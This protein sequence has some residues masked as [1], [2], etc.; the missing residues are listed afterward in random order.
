MK[1]VSKNIFSLLLQRVSFDLFINSLKI[2][3]VII[4]IIVNLI[5]LAGLIFLKW[6]PVDILV[7][8]WI[9]SVVV[10]MVNVPKI[11]FAKDLSRSPFKSTIPGQNYDSQGRP[12]SL[13]GF[14]PVFGLFGKLLNIFTAFFFLFHYGFFNFG[15]WIFINF[16][17]RTQVPDSSWI[18]L[19]DRI[20]VFFIAT[21]ISHSFSFLYN[22]IGKGE[23][24][25]TSVNEQM[26]KPYRRVL[27]LQIT[28]I[29]GGMLSIFI[30]EYIIVVFVVV[31]IYLDILS[32]INSHKEVFTQDV[33]GDK[34]I[35][36]INPNSS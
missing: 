17:S 19:D 32:H 8:Y 2:P 5:P 1:T 13:A 7:L 29:F 28:I 20:M 10:G 9:E 35:N 15:H 34:E 11:I 31:K 25:N 4:L 18:R 22:Y 36:F 21:L 24:L 33:Y 3:S 27:V 12:Y 14:H 30:S 16:I 26:I 6:D 23:Y